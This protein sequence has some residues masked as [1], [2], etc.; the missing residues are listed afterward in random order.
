MEDGMGKKCHREYEKL[1]LFSWMIPDS[2]QRFFHLKT[3][4]YP[5]LGD[6]DLDGMPDPFAVYSE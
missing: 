6:R 2:A 3:V 4:S 1:S 5:D